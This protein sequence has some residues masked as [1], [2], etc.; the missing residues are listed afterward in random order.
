MTG[1]LIL[2]VLLGLAIVIPLGL[3]WMSTDSGATRFI[4]G[5]VITGVTLSVSAAGNQMLHADQQKSRPHSTY[6]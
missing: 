1:T 2:L 3:W 6:P 5:L 4:L